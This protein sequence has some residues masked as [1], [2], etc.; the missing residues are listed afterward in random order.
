MNSRSESNILTKL[1]FYDK[2]KGNDQKKLHY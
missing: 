1:M 2:A